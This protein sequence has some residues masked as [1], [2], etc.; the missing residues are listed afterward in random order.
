PAAPAKPVVTAES[1][2]ANGDPGS[3]AAPAETFAPLVRT[4]A[5]AGPAFLFF[6]RHHHVAARLRSLIRARL[7]EPAGSLLDPRLP[8][9]LDEVW[10]TR[11]V[12]RQGTPIAW[13]SEQ[14]AAVAFGLINPL[15]FVAGGPGTGKTCVLSALTRALV[16][17]GVPAERI[18][19]A[20]P[21]GRA[22]Q[23]M[24]QSL[25][26]DLASLADPAP[27]DRALL[28]VQ[29]ATLHRLLDFLPRENRFRR[30][31]FNPVPADAVLVDEASM[32]DIELMAALLE[33]VPPGARLVLIGDPAQLPPVEVGDVLA[34]LLPDSAAPA[35]SP[36]RRRWLEELDAAP[37]L[38]SPSAP[39]GEFLDR[40]V[41]LTCNYR[42]QGALDEIARAVRAGSS[43]ILERLKPAPPRAPSSLPT[44]APTS[45]PTGAA[46][47]APAG[48]DLFDPDAPP[49]RWIDAASPE[50]PAWAAVAE[51]FLQRQF[52]DAPIGQP[53]YFQR[54][55]D[56]VGL[57]ADRWIAPDSRPALA[58][59]FDTLQRA[60]IL[61]ALRRGPFGADNV[62]RYF[63]RRIRQQLHLPPGDAPFAGLPILI[64]QNDPDSGLFNGDLGILLSDAEAT[65]F[66]VFPGPDGY[67]ALPA[68][69][70]PAFQPAFA[71]TV[72]KSQG[73]EF[74]RVLIALPGVAE[75]RLATRE[76]L[77]TALTRA[78]RAACIFASEPVLR[79]ALEHA[80]LRDDRWEL[81]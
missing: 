63:V 42:A 61:T 15:T 1:P 79:A 64:L 59:L 18:V 35:F 12:R 75:H 22:A 52:F 68:A 8:P 36:A 21:T 9:A 69:T 7:A 5:G 43:D 58:A 2:A 30:H 41:R 3:R 40:V 55:A 77:Y 62:N 27:A 76:L 48:F 39:S 78:R 67:R 38:S 80:A 71:M 72:H 47:A 29:S 11:P 13:N 65:N 74:D 31:R 25:R 60:R 28:A 46:L 26:D 23:R 45:M 70:L 44:S 81:C 16:R 6:E 49:C 33:A 19:L 14:R 32:I 17:C 56:V 4:A 66:A 10:R 53:T 57:P 37:A 73:S 20:A 24:T 34:R 50:A 51:T 54:L